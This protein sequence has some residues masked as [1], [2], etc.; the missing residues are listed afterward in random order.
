MEY[1]N[2][3]ETRKNVKQARESYSVCKVVKLSLEFVS[4]QRKLM[5]SVLSTYQSPDGVLWSIICPKA[6]HLLLTTVKLCLFL[7]SIIY[8][9]KPSLRQ[10][11]QRMVSHLILP[12][13]W[14]GQ[15][16]HQCLRCTQRSR[17]PSLSD[18][19]ELATLVISLPLEVRS[20]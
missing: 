10:A 19:R 9:H 18:L 1:F 5:R 14:C 2:D 7:R 12:R 8:I 20:R 17:N 13:R 4:T 11:Q 3:N 6:L 16:G 15:H